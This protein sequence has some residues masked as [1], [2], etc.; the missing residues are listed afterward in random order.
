MPISAVLMDKIIERIILGVQ[1]N[2]KKIF[3][4]SQLTSAGYVPVDTGFLKS[5]GAIQ[6]TAKG[7]I[8]QYTAPYAADVEYGI[9]TDRPI[10]GD[11][12]VT[13]TNAQG[14]TTTVIYRNK[15]LIRIYPNKAIRG[16]PLY[17]VIAM[18]RARPGQYFM[19]RA[20][21]VKIVELKYDIADALRDLGTVTV[22]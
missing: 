6:V 11:Q 21:R 17:R 10:V 3:S 19:S 13:R 22:S 5:T 15:K 20:A 7:A 12:K 8:I 2:A 14:V 18:E 1:A 16:K 9:A 4:L